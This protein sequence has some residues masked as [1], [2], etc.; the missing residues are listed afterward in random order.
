MRG[1]SSITEHMDLES[2]CMPMAIL[3]KGSGKKT[4]KMGEE[5]SNRITE[6][7]M[8]ESGRT[9]CSRALESKSGIF[10]TYL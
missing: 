10:F 4:S 9:T 6:A 5:S 2:M 8:M 3:T 7:S 1:S